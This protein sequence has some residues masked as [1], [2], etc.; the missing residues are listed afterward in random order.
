MVNIN[1]CF[2]VFNFIPDQYKLQE[3]CDTVVSNDPSIIVECLDKYITQKM[4]DKAV[5]KDP[6]LTAY[7]PDK[8]ITQKRVMKLLMIL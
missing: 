5:Y 1:K 4:C 2:F 3:M 6:F 7:C 8:Y